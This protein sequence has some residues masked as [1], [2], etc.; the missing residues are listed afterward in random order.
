M[1]LGYLEQPPQAATFV[2][3]AQEFSP[4]VLQTLQSVKAVC[5]ELF[6]KLSASTQAL[7][8]ID[9]VPVKLSLLASVVNGGGGGWEKT[10][11]NASFGLM[12]RA[13]PMTKF[14][15]T[16]FY[17]ALTGGDD[18]YNYE[19]VRGLTSTH[20]GG[21]F[22]FEKLVVPVGQREGRW[23]LLC[24]DLKRRHIFSYNFFES[25]DCNEVILNIK[26][27]LHDENGDKT[28]LDFHEW[29]VEESTFPSFSESHG[30]YLCFLAERFAVGENATTLDDQLDLYQRRVAFC[31]LLP[32]LYRLNSKAM[33]QLTGSGA[34]SKA[35]D[36]TTDLV[37]QPT[38]T[39]TAAI[40]EAPQPPTPLSVPELPV[41]A[42]SQAVIDRVL[43]D[44]NNGE[45]DAVLDIVLRRSALQVSPNSSDDFEATTIS[46]LTR[47]DAACQNIPLD[48]SISLVN[49]DGNPVTAPLLAGIVAHQAWLDDE[50]INGYFGLLAKAMPSVKFMS[51]F[52]FTKLTAGAADGLGYK[53]EAVR[54]W[55]R[56]TP[57]GVFGFEKVVV[58]INQ[59]NTHWSVICVDLQRTH[60]ENYDS[61]GGATFGAAAV[62][63]IM[64]YLHDEHNDKVVRSTEPMPNSF[65]EGGWTTRL[66]STPRQRDGGSC[67]VFACL[68]AKRF[69]EGGGV[70]AAWGRDGDV[71]VFRRSMA[72]ALLAPLVYSVLGPGQA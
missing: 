23:S 70:P 20:G 18:E 50:A 42:I 69:C 65:D 59:G 35:S 28:H 34:V 24:V 40:S 21:I 13:F 2:D 66:A 26:T 71:A 38:A 43:R 7:V 11:I 55:T 48:T 32:L 49:I 12:S 52:F 9:G 53:Y 56:K 6:S 10:A 63:V 45:E 17:S 36:E 44:Q 27:Y 41:S 46:A 25:P 16:S 37:S 22:G 30:L 5:D 8:V 64:R 3:R 39:S 60:I 62:S 29:T 31:L 4:A 14:M 68:Y 15:S 47:F 61:L 1:Y 51:T 57:K 54:R 33:P 67:G 72:F 58:P 19:A